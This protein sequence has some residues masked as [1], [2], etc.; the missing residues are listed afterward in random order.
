MLPANPIPVFTL[1]QY[2]TSAL[3]HQRQGA[4]PVPFLIFSG[5][6]ITMAPLDGNWS[7]LARLARPKQLSQ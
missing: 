2:R 4:D 1:K 6:A 3:G 7:R 5:V